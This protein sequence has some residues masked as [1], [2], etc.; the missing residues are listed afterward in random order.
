M[1]GSTNEHSDA[2]NNKEQRIDILGGGSS[3]TANSNPATPNPP[4]KAAD[5]TP[6]LPP[7]E[8][9][10]L[11][12]DAKLL[13]IAIKLIDVELLMQDDDDSDNPTIKKSP[14]QIKELGK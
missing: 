14:D 3:T 7:P 11:D 9:L 12:Q 4:P 13:A 2:E 10:S 8:A 1:C 6:A 5:P